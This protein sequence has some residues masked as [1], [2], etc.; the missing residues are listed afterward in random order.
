MKE[1]RSDNTAELHFAHGPVEA[2][3]PEGF[4]AY[5][6]VGPYFR[7]IKPPTAEHSGDDVLHRIRNFPKA[8]T[9]EDQMRI[10]MRGGVGAVPVPSVVGSGNQSAQEAID[11]L[12]RIME[13][14]GPFD[15]IVGYSEGATVAATLLL[16]EQRRFE[17]EGRPPMFKCA[18]FFAGWPP[19]TPDLASIVLADESDLTINIPTCHISKWRLSEHLLI[20]FL[21]SS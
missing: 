5:F 17:V 11:Y 14:V 20:A 3:P 8:S 12:Y 1:L 18:L 21:S 7:F 9:A 13:D 6:G 4:E 15:G 19:M 10:L 2:F 16:H